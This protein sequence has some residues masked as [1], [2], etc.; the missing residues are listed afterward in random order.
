[1]KAYSMEDTL[2][3]DLKDGLK[4]KKGIT[5]RSNTPWMRSPL[6]GRTHSPFPSPSPSAAT[7]TYTSGSHFIDNGIVMSPRAAFE[8]SNDCPRQYKL[9]IMEA[10]KN[11]WIQPVAYMKESE[12]V[13]EKLKE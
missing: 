12:Y 5:P 4:G 2:K 13:W 3:H 10:I 7:S 6:P 9:M 11:G 1:M 8:I